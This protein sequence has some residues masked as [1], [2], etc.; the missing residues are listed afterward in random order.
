MSRRQD[1]GWALIEVVASL[2][3]LSV[4]LGA[5]YGAWLSVVKRV[6][7]TEDMLTAP[8]DQPGSETVPWGWGAAVAGA[9]WENGPSLRIKLSGPQPGDVVLGVWLNGWFAAEY[10]VAPESESTPLGDFLFWQG[11]EG[12][13]VVVRARAAEAGWGPPWRTIVP[14]IVAGMEEPPGA[15]A[16]STV[17]VHFPFLASAEAVVADATDSTRPVSGMGCAPL[18]AAGEWLTVSVGNES[19]EIVGGVRGLDLYF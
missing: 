1:G 16:V 8:T 10:P 19:Q 5:L 6:A 14:A 13:E 9:D 11:R 18:E 4:I 7:R 12:E 17:L 3:L 2:V 15:A